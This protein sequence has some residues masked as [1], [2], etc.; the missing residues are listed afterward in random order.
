MI[1]ICITAL[2]KK[3]LLSANSLTHE[4]VF[5]PIIYGCAVTIRTV[6]QRTDKVI[7]E[8]RISLVHIVILT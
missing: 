5:L 2:H 3:L 4:I 6:L 7:S 8:S 1:N